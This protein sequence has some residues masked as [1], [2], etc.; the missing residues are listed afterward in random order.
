MHKVEL[1]ARN[2]KNKKVNRYYEGMSSSEEEAKMK[3][4]KYVR[5]IFGDSDISTHKVSIA[6]KANP[7]KKKEKRERYR[8][9]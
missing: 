9:D 1:T 8:D 2:E 7:K 4:E 3:A 6:G 5:D